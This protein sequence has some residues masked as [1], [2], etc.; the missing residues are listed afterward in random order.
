MKKRFADAWL[1]VPILVLASACSGGEPSSEE[2]RSYEIPDALCG[3]EIDRDLFDPLFPPGEAIEEDGEFL[4]AAGDGSFDPALG[5]HVWVDEI[6][7]VAVTAERTR[8][9]GVAAVI[10]ELNWEGGSEGSESLPDGP[11]EAQVWSDRAIAYVPCPGDLPD[12]VGFG[13][14]IDTTG[15]EEDHSETLAQ[16]IGPYTEAFLAHMEPGACPGT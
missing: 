16:V 10:E 8:S 13:V 4:D 3:V 11:F 6:S 9:E 12:Y 15:Q 14:A 2:E 5:C 7:A 1:L